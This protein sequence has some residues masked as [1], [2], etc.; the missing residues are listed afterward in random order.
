MAAAIVTWGPE[1][2]RNCIF[3][4]MS[5][6]LLLTGLTVVFILVALVREWAAPALVITAGMVLLLVTGVISPT[7]A[8]SGFS[9]QAPVTIAALLVVSRAVER[10]G[11]LRPL[12]ERAIRRNGS[13][14]TTLMR[15]LAPT[16]AISAFMNNTPIV[17]M[18]IGPVIATAER[19]GRSP[20]TF[21]MPLNHA[22]LLGGTV[23][24]IGTSSNLVV[25][26]LM[27]ESGMPAMGMF[28]LSPLALPVAIVGVFALVWLSPILLP[29]RRGLKERFSEEFREFSIEMEVEPSG[30]VAGRT[31]ADAGLR[32][33]EGVFLAWVRRGRQL[34][35]PVGPEETLCDGDV[36]GFVGSVGRVMDLK[37]IRG[38]RLAAHKHVR[39]LD[40]GA[41]RFVEVVLAAM[42]PLV[43]RTLKEAGFR[44][45]YQA[46]VLAVHRSGDRLAGKLGEV[47]LEAGDTLLLLAD[48]G[49]VARWRDRRD[50]LLVSAVNGSMPVGTRKSWFVLLVA[51][52]MIAASALEI[53]PIL[54]GSLVAALLMVLGRILTPNEARAA[55]DL[56][57]LLMVAA[58]YSIGKA[59]ET[60]GLATLLANLLVAP[61]MAIGPTAVLGGVVVATLAVTQ[62]ITNNAAAVLVFPI[63]VAAATQIGADPRPFALSVA[64]ASSG[65]FL[66]PIGYQ[67]NTMIFGPGGYRFGDYIR[68]GLPLSLLMLSGIVGMVV[69]TG[70]L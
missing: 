55:V 66:T 18:L 43:G 11:G 51:A 44:E 22:V 34:I 68:L 62:L 7:E 63:A 50:F 33:L 12:L 40:A 30:L 48:Q 14:R 52:A 37:E 16:A 35:T 59:I 24:L 53:V 36:L 39:G 26:G 57:V 47:K 9:S 60:S 4:H 17:A 2:C 25:S 45:Q 54:Q 42:S 21:L 13:E 6:H 8:L 46:T 23:T 49:F 27:Q 67:T 70:S 58:S 3:S 5:T 28:E 15:L 20:S 10:T 61:A 32:H 69:L 64:I 29:A 41:H 19:G 56:D 31:V 1:E 38:L 65:A